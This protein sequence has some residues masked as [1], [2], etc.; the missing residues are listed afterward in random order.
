M[1]SLIPGFAGR[2]GATQRVAGGLGSSMN[3]PTA[4]PAPVTALRA[5]PPSTWVRRT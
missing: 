5:A 1:F 2:A 4:I 3:V